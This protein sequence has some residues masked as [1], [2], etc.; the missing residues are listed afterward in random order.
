MTKLIIIKDETSL[1]QSC[2]YDTKTKYC[3]QGKLRNF[4]DKKRNLARIIDCGVYDKDYEDA[5]R[6]KIGGIR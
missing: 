1:C 2:Q 5:S 6:I 4:I 3:L